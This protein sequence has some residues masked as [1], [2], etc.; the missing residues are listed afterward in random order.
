M[1][2]STKRK[3]RAKKT[4]KE[5]FIELLGK[6]AHQFML[7]AVRIG[8]PD[9]IM[10]SRVF[11]LGA[12]FNPKIAASRLKFPQTKTVTV[13]AN[14]ARLRWVKA[15]DKAVNDS[16]QEAELLARVFESGEASTDLWKCG[17][18]IVIAAC[19]HTVKGL[20]RYHADPQMIRDI[21]PY[22]RIF[23]KRQMRK[24]FDVIMATLPADTPNFYAEMTGAKKN[25]GGTK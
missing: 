18:M 17:R 24:Y 15:T 9:E 12:E 4:D 14:P 5:R 22:A 11:D 6:E 13:T 8:V 20:S 23:A 21:Y 16:V 1:K 25:K 19:L 7:D 10:T 3:R 2:S